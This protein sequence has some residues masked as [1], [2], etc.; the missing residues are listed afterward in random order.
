MH[1]YG[2]SAGRG[3]GEGGRGVMM[4]IGVEE[5]NIMRIIWVAGDEAG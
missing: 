1:A 4:E 5:E 3:D 2:A